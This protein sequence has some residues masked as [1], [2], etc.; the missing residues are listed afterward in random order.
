M[1]SQIKYIYSFGIWFA[2]IQMAGNVADGE[3]WGTTCAGP[4]DYVVQGN[5]IFIIRQPSSAGIF[6]T[7]GALGTLHHHVNI[8]QLFFLHRQF[9]QNRLSG[10]ISFLHARWFQDMLI[11]QILSFFFKINYLIIITEFWIPSIFMLLFLFFV[12]HVMLDGFQI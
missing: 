7:P 4:G 5:W 10:F 12:Q 6:I 2:A 1:S 8:Y 3:Q 9:D 11:I